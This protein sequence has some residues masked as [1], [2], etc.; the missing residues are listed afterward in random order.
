MKALKIFISSAQKEFAAERRA[1]AHLIENDSFLLGYFELLLQRHFKSILF[2]DLPA[3]IGSFQEIIIS[4][5]IFIILI[6]REYGSSDKNKLSPTQQEYRLARSLRKPCLVFIKGTSQTPMDPKSRLFVQEIQREDLTYQQF[7]N[8]KDLCKMIY[9]SL[10]QL[11]H[12]MVSFDHLNDIASGL[13]EE[14]DFLLRRAKKRPH[15]TF[16]SY[17]GADKKLVCAVI[18]ILEYH[19]ADVYI[20]YRDSHLPEDVTTE[21]AQALKS[22][23]QDARCFILFLTPNSKNSRWIPW[24]LGLCDGMKSSSSVALFPSV[25]N[26]DETIF[27]DREYLTLYQR[28]S[29]G[30]TDGLKKINDLVVLNHHTNTTTPLKKW[31]VR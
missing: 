20:D 24:E 23:I 6:G 2:E 15:N 28:I 16:L 14:S 27:A 30:I 25:K 26:W 3:R 10:I 4:A 22:A 13:P 19:G 21:T 7:Y 29:F 11:L 5:D 17:S 31:I 18:S 1:I 12:T 8:V 9:A